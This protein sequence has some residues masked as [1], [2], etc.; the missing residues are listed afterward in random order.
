MPSHDIPPPS[1][2]PPEQPSEDSSIVA[3]VNRPA[4]PVRRATADDRAAVVATLCRAFDAD[5]AVSWLLRAD[6][7][8][9]DAFKTAFDVTFRK[10]CLPSNE[11][12]IAGDGAGVA[13]WTPPGEW[14]IWR[15]IWDLPSLAGAIGLTRGPGV[16][17]AVSRVQKFHPAAPHW[18]LFAIGVAPEQQGRGI[19]AALLGEVLSRCD[20]RKE[21]AYLEASTRNNARLYARHG[22]VEIAE[23]PLADG[24]PSCW[25]MW[26]DPR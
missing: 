6:A 22:F 20:E 14:K 5:P 7:K 13:L 3:R 15:A 8:R 16:V 24:A 23:V 1:H 18:Y 11:S 19:G 10:L 9:A 17:A 2:D 21:P 4:V 12:W 26:R 25:P